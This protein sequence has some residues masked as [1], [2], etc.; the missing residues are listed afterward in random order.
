MS[1]VSRLLD[2]ANEGQMAKVFR[3]ENPDRA[4]AEI[5]ELLAQ[6]GWEDDYGE[7][8]AVM[9]ARDRRGLKQRAQVAYEER[10]IVEIE[11][12][13][14]ALMSGVDRHLDESEEGEEAPFTVYFENCERLA[15]VVGLGQ[16]G[17]PAGVEAGMFFMDMAVG[18]ERAYKRLFPWWPVLPH[19]QGPYGEFVNEL[20]TSGSHDWTVPM[21]P[22]LEEF[23]TVVAEINYDSRWQHWWLQTGLRDVTLD[24][25]FDPAM[26]LQDSGLRSARRHGLEVRVR[27]NVG[28]GEPTGCDGA[29]MAR[30][31]VAESLAV[32]ARKI[33]A[34]PPPPLPLRDADHE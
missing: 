26:R 30:T 23:T 13:A 10:V 21:L 33:G 29:A 6:A 5:R 18:Y 14:S 4:T 7:P 9:S 25:E 8:D 2:C 28:T 19:E 15:P 32:C 17:L 22:F 1:L 11:D 16:H 31:L 24:G 27:L 3:Q 12:E 34:A 20:L